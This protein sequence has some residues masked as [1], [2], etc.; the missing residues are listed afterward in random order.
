MASCANAQPCNNRR[1]HQYHHQLNTGGHCS[2][3]SD[4][5]EHIAKPRPGAGAHLN[6]EGAPGRHHRHHNHCHQ[7]HVHHRHLYSHHHLMLNFVMKVRL[8]ITINFTTTLS[9]STSPSMMS[10]IVLKRQTTDYPLPPYTML[11]EF[12]ND[13]NLDCSSRHVP[14]P[15]PTWPPLLPNQ[16]GITR[17][18]DIDIDFD[19]EK[20]LTLTLTRHWQGIDIDMDK[21][22]TRHWHDFSTAQNIAHFPHYVF[23][24]KLTMWVFLGSRTLQVV[25]IM[26][27]IMSKLC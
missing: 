10:P 15:R 5:H 19:I 20:M 12:E 7:R 26:I 9:V 23:I 11:G 16:G 6:D 13:R 8:I 14:L 25:L 17:G 1:H 22:L 27:T 24:W 3:F 18:Q 4:A 21:T 2:R